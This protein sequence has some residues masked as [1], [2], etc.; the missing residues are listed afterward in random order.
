MYKL[1]ILSITILVIFQLTFNSVTKIPKISHLV[2]ASIC[3][4]QQ[5]NIHLTTSSSLDLY[6]RQCLHPITSFSIVG[7]FIHL[8]IERILGRSILNYC[9]LKTVSQQSLI[10]LMNPRSAID[11]PAADRRL[12]A[13]SL[14]ER[15]LARK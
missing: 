12:R 11:A 15:I 6:S 4:F 14:T 8:S 1:L 7:H 3:H 13:D 10:E 9:T 5:L 2:E